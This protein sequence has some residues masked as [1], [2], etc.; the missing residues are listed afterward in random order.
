MERSM[1]VTAPSSL[2]ARSAVRVHVSAPYVRTGRTRTLNR[3]CF[4]I[5]PRGLRHRAR[6][7]RKAC[8]ARE[9][10]WSTSTSQLGSRLPSSLTRS[11][12][13]TREPSRRKRGGGGLVS[14]TARASVFLLTSSPTARASRAR[15]SSH[16]CTCSVSS[17][18]VVSSA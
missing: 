9:M 4:S 15:Q 18:R 1:L 13:R 7:W 6:Y 17:K 8:Q 11:R 10:R 14:P 12:Y 16:V 3:S 5:L 2:R